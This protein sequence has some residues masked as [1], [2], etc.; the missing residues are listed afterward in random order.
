LVKDVNQDGF[1]DLMA[2]GNHFGTEVFTGKY[3]ASVGW[4][5]E[6]NGK[7]GF[8]VKLPGESGFFVR[9]DARAL[10]HLTLADGGSAILA[11]QNNDSLKVMRV[12]PTHGQPMQIPTLV[13]SALM[14]FVDG[15]TQRVEFP[16]GNTYLSQ[17]SRVLIAPPGVVSI[18]LYGFNGEVISE[19]S[20]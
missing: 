18:R 2:V 20:L 7:G 3:A 6:G 16:F 14:T 5:A 8:K 11:T 13:A 17:S 12:Q 4:Y 19:E 15:R 10:A 9:G 1:P